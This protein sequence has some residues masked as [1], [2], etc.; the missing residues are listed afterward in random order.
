MA[1][2]AR[3]CHQGN[4]KGEAEVKSQGKHSEISEEWS[5]E[6]NFLQRI[7]ENSRRIQ[8]FSLGYT[9][10][11]WP[12]ENRNKKILTVLCIYVGKQK[13]LIGSIFTAKII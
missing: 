8:G 9:K 11:L 1:F 3:I 2:H 13:Y 4:E 12:H 7:D 10:T 6:E 5:T